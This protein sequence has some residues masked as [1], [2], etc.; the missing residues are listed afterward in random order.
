M[1]CL[2]RSVIVDILALYAA[3]SFSTLAAMSPLPFLTRSVICCNLLL[4][5]TWSAS[6]VLNMSPL[7]CFT[8]A[9]I[10]DILALY[11]TWSASTALNTSP[12]PFLTR[13]VIC[14]NLVLY[15]T[16]SF[17]FVLGIVPSL[18]DSAILYW[19]SETVI[20]VVLLPGTPMS[21]FCHPF[22]ISLVL[23][24]IRSFCCASVRRSRPFVGSIV[25]EFVDLFTR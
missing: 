1:P 2:T 22:L 3:W 19:C 21:S 10:L 25:S 15:A 7:P 11:T 8:F 18:T 24:L 23:F 14:S 13:S 4:Y 5:T 6:T 9:A 16:W 17:S 12:L 20:V